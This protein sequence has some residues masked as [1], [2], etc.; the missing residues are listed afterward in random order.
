MKKKNFAGRVAEAEKKKLRRKAKRGFRRVLLMIGGGVGL[1]CA[2]YCF[3][4][5]HKA[6]VKLLGQ[7]EEWKTRFCH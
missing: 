3:G 5:H 7:K 1:F 2:G 4:L 6:I